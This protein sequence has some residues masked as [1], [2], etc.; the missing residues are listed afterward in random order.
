[1][2]LAI[3]TAIAALCSSGNSKCVRN[4]RQCFDSHRIQMESKI[5]NCYGQ[6][7]ADHW[8]CENLYFDETETVYNCV[9]EKGNG[10]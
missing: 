9:Y 7:K 4:A 8:D 2:T 6:R 3:L 1:M 5:N 10:K